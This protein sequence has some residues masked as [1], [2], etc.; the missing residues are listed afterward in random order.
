M[1]FLGGCAS[2]EPAGKYV[3][4]DGAGYLTVV[5]TLRMDPELEALVEP[6][7]EDMAE[8]V[9]RVIGHATATLTKDSPEGTL[10]NMAADA[11]LH[12]ISADIAITN[13]GGLRVP[14]AEGPITVGHMFELMP[15]ENMLVVLHLTGEQ[16]LALANDLAATNGEPVAGISLEIAEGG[17]ARNVRVAGQPVEPGR[18]YRVAT[19]DYL[20]N[21]G[22]NMP[23]LWLDVHR[24][25]PFVT[26]RDA[27]IAYVQSR[28]TIEPVL[29]GR[30][31]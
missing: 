15:F 1:F 8:E 10:G 21:G 11:M 31:K 7:R 17:T 6:Y 29:E 5:D 2:L 27:F 23:A 18:T 26:L 3:P 25:E 19:S 22:G 13:N 28:G 12:A 9:S 4:E 20:A 30:I 24:E 16:V 14:L